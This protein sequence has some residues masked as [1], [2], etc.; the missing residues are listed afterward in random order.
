MFVH[1][2]KTKTACRDYILFCFFFRPTEG[3]LLLTPLV[4]QSGILPARAASR[5]PEIFAD[6]EAYSGYITVDE[7][8][9]SHLF[10]LHMKMPVRLGNIINMTKCI[11]R[12]NRS[13]PGL[14]L[15]QKPR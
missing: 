14:N 6:L 8:N 1:A 4:Q 12:F 15:A 11:A 9:E 10:F 5:V 2:Y 7:K 3:A 13:S